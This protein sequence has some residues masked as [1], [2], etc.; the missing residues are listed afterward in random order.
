[1]VLFFIQAMATA[2]WMVTFS[3]VLSAH[4][5]EGIIPY[6]F[7]STGVA[8]IV[9]T[10][11]IGSLADQHI[12]A[13]RLLRWLAL[14]TS[15]SLFAAFFAIEKGWGAGWV[16]VGMQL[17]ALFSA[18][19]WGLAT[20]I[21]LTSLHD[22]ARQFGAI[23][24]WATFGWMTAGAV[25]SFLL[26]AETSATNGMIAA[27]IWL[28]VFAIS[29]SLPSAEPRNSKAGRSWGALL[30]LD[31]LGL[32]RHRSHGVVFITAALVSAPLAAFY[33][34]AAMQLRELGAGS[35]AAL[36]ALGQVSE[37]GAMYAL[38][39]ILARVR[40]KWILSAGIAFG[41]AR[42]ALF[43]LD[44][45]PTVVAGIILHGLC[46]TLFVIPTQIYLDQRIEPVFH[47]RAQA[48]LTFM[49]SGLGTLAGYLGCGWWREACRTA[50]GTRWPLFWGVLTGIMVAV[51][52]FF[53]A[54]YRGRGPVGGDPAQE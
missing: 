37:V 10:L 3:N 24:V 12:S 50:E 53:V 35:I 39:P 21:A 42:Y 31:A 17:Q 33:P 44:T 8:A 45:L 51:L 11:F 27:G 30:G 34:F 22:S 25:T 48:L 1:M 47:A 2:M 15:V 40:L 4:G 5:L 49:M 36:M 7:A 16:L 23:R 14:G 13:H 29:Y 28:G 19:T 52:V 41:I 6:A 26:R 18:P 20:T 9:S 38:S 54:T 46:F 43:S 32:L